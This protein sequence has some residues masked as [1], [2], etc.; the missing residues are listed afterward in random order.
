M[1]NASSTSGY[2]SL[3]VW[4]WCLQVCL[5]DPNF[6][7]FVDRVDG[8]WDEAERRVGHALEARDF[9]AMMRRMG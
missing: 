6:Q 4:F 1:K 8:L 9:V 3:S 7:A 5:E 2:T